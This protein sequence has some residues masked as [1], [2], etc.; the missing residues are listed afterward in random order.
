MHDP[1]TVD[2]PHATPPGA[3]RPLEPASKPSLTP[4]IILPLALTVGAFVMTTIAVA[5]AVLREGLGGATGDAARERLEA[6]ATAPSTI[7]TGV[8]LIVAL[9]L[10]L[11]VV[12]T[13]RARAPVR[14]TLRLRL[15]PG[16]F[17]DGLLA[18]VVVIA[19]G[20]VLEIAARAV[21]AYEGSSLEKTMTLVAE[22]PTSMLLI[23]SIPTALAGVH[24]E[25]IFRGFV[26][27]RLR[28]HYSPRT[29]LV[30]TS[31]AFGLMHFDPLHVALATLIGLA[32]GR[33]ADASDSVV[34]VV[35]A[36]VANNALSFA[37]HRFAPVPEDALSRL[38][39]AVVAAAVGLAAAHQL[40]ARHA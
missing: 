1:M 4:A 17:V 38:G 27:T 24:E 15:Y 12:F 19:L 34:P 30:V 40:R 22:A 31:V 3:E 7:T 26:Q 14:E 37:S 18:S 36:H 35:I 23:V 11:T 39:V 33:I 32:L 5:A 2:G 16:V 6:I 9:G 20:T 10:G 21:G 25:L 28:L 29:A 13:L 8:A